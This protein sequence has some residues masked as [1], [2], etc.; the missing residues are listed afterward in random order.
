MVSSTDVAT[1]NEPLLDPGTQPE[2]AHRSEQS[3]DE[4]SSQRPRGGTVDADSDDGSNTDGSSLSH[5]PGEATTTTGLGSTIVMGRK[6]A[7]TLWL[8]CTVTML[9]QG[10]RTCA[11]KWSTS[12]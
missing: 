4:D 8:D 11:Y 10:V 3:G 6:L 2:V 5:E 9:A 7:H 1:L 12:G